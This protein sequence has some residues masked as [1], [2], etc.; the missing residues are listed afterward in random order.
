MTIERGAGRGD[1]RATGDGASPSGATEATAGSPSS[2]LSSADLI[3]LFRTEQPSLSRAVRRRIGDAEDAADIV[4]DAFARL[5]QARPAAALRAPRAYLQRIVSN[6]LRDRHKRAET[7]LVD[8][9]AVWTAAELATVPAEQGWAIEA[10]ELMTA[11]AAAVAALSPRTREV[12]LMHRVEEL[13]Y[14]DIAERLGITVAT[15]EYHMARALAHLDK[16]LD[17]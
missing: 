14:R 1:P 12:F 15:V 6:L 11:Y 4:Q 5:L 13:R 2:C 9:N 7:R 16:A 17:R 8:R 10:K 3:R